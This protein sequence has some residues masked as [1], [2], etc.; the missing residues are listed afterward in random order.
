MATCRPTAATVLSAVGLI[1]AVLLA[2]CSGEGESEPS[3]A[4]QASRATDAGVV[5][6][7]DGVC[8]A[9]TDLEDAVAQVTA[10]LQPGPEAKT[11]VTERV[12]AVRVAVDDLRAAVNTSPPGV[13]SEEVAA[14][15]DEL[16]AATG[17]AGA[18]AEDL[19]AQGTTLAEAQTPAELATALS[20]AGAALATVGTEVRAYLTSL[21]E[22][23]AS[24]DPALK[25]AFAEAPA[26][27]ARGVSPSP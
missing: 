13:V 14:A 27:Q 10:A 20:A 23:A 22:A 18:A 12:G 4:A 17:S 1:V 6:W 24:R 11:E 21:R 7:A 19:A 2:G 8:A 16:S 15:R 3:P 5:M 9:T 26:C 25:S